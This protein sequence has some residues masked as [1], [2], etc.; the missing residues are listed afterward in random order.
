MSF[1]LR[2]RGNETYADHSR[3]THRL[4]EKENAASDDSDGFE[5]RPDR[6]GRTNTL[7]GNDSSR[8]IEMIDIIGKN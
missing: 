3:D 6:I 5:I 2:S 7:F 4:A 8:C 1:G